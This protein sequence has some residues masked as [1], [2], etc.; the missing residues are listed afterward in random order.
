ML[1]EFD[2]D[3]NR[4][5]RRYEEPLTRNPFIELNGGTASFRNCS[6]ESVAARLLMET[7]ALSLSGGPPKAISG[8]TEPGDVDGQQSR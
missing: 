3:P 1:R 5:E 6:L 4:V 2:L 8:G 7:I